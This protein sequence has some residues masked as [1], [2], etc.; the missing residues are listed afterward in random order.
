[1]LILASPSVWA[2]DDAFLVTYTHEL[3]EPGNLEV[4]M[5]SVTG[6]PGGGN[7]FLGGAAEFEYSLSRWWMT[8]VYVDGQTTRGMG[9]AFTGYRWE[10]RFRILQ[11]E[12]WINPV[13]YVEF[14][15]INGADK[16]LLDVVGHDRY[17]DLVAP[18]NLT[19]RER[20]REVEAK[21][22]LGSSFKAWTLA[23][24]LV[25]EKNIRHAPYEFG[26]SI[27]IS[28]ALAHAAKQDRCNFCAKNLQLGVEMYGGLGTYD[29]FGL[30]ATSHYVAPV[31]AW[32]L[33][34]GTTFRLSPGFG[35][36]HASAPCLLR[37]GLSYGIDGFGHTVRNLFHRQS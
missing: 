4:G 34:N 18:N 17:H 37:L 31:M 11:H 16:A 36:T 7:R 33:A 15:D 26:Y 19:V 9:A 10:N 21:L 14:E 12:H 22:I 1:L 6:K 25:V 8:E 30:R 28:R 2:G 13:V 27:G 23:E 29:D 35:V 3:E 32:T 24:N 5:K 20:N